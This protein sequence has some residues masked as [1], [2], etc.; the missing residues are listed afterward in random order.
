V[1]PGDHRI[2]N[3]ISVVPAKRGI[4]ITQRVKVQL[5]KSESVKKRRGRSQD[6]IIDSRLTI[7]E[8]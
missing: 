7:L 2:I 8:E 3:G 5:R 4:G 1:T 6:I